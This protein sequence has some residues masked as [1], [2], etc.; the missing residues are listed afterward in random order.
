PKPAI[1][2]A[3]SGLAFA[4]IWNGEREA[5]LA[6]ATEARE[7][8]EQLRRDGVDNPWYAITYAA[9]TYSLLGD[10]AAARREI[11]R[12]VNAYAKDAFV[13]PQ[14]LTVLARVEAQA[15]EVDGALAMLENVLKMP[16]AY[17]VT[18]AL[19]RVEPVWDSIRSDPRFQKLCEEKQP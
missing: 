19:L 14:A 11:E 12:A 5:G 6:H 16:C 15:G 9:Q 10:H 3:L 2:E 7:L 13:R 1:G 8:F 4:E 17:A 18:P